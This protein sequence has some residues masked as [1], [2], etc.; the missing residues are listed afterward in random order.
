MRTGTTPV[1]CKSFFKPGSLVSG[2]FFLWL[3]TGVSCSKKT[4]P[5]HELD[6]AGFGVKDTAFFKIIDSLEDNH[7]TPLAL[8]TL[9]SA[10]ER[11]IRQP[12]N[13]F[14]FLSTRAGM[15]AKAGYSKSAVP[16]GSE[17]L[18]LA[19]K[20]NDT[21]L[22]AHGYLGLGYIFLMDNYD[23]AAKKYIDKAALLL[24]AINNDTTVL[25]RVLNNQAVYEMMVTKNLPRAMDITKQE[26][27]IAR[28]RN[29]LDNLTSAFNN[30]TGVYYYAQK[31]DSALMYIDSTIELCRQVN[32]K[33]KLATTFINKS[34]FCLDL[35]KTDMAARYADSAALL[36]GSLKLHKPEVPLAR[37]LV[38]KEKKEFAGA[39]TAFELY[40]S[41][42]RVVQANR[43]V[44]LA[45]LLESEQKVSSI[46]QQMRTKDLEHQANIASYERK[47]TAAIVLGAGL[48]VMLLLLGYIYKGEVR[49]RK[50][51]QNNL[52]QAESLLRE[53]TMLLSETRQ[54]TINRSYESEMEAFRRKLSMELHDNVAGALAGMKFKLSM[55]PPS[56]LA[57]EVIDNIGKIYEKV[58]SISHGLVSYKP[59]A[60]FP[61]E[62]RRLVTGYLQG[63]PL[64]VT[65]S[66]SNEAQLNQLPS[67]LKEQIHLIIQ[68]ILANVIKHSGATS[69]SVTVSVSDQQVLLGF[70]DNGCGFEVE[71]IKSG[72]GLQNINRRLHELN[73]ALEVQSVQNRGATT[74]ISIPVTI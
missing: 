66:I 47:K 24:P 71:K 40:D 73:G 62:I 55:L 1:Q 43:E 60:D 23:S 4:K 37:Y 11:L 7:S 21:L 34:S 13:W 45:D 52:V 30:M 20:M 38:L 9:D 69:F 25:M 61:E 16:F 54:N 44:V 51:A 27:A 39:L 15:L 17:A 36:F 35:K 72:I 32:N 67:M 58:R 8:K 31:P 12:V 42:N 50:L 2:L 10:R 49:R 57:G 18:E 65:L 28:S 6:P 64:K 59:T 74:S 5:G 14:Y 53:R 70:A 26:L 29:N 46:E 33:F 3:F 48:L 41:L 63:L 68:E 56:A 19:E 22:L